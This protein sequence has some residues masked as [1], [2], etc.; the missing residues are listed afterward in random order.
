MTR[1]L[2]RKRRRNPFQIAGTALLVILIAIALVL[3]VDTFDLLGQVR[4]EMSL[5]P[6]PLPVMA[7]VM[8]VTPD[9]N[10]PTAEPLIKNGAEGEEVAK[11][12]QRLFDL[13]FYEGT[14]DGQFGQGTQNA[15]T[16]F[17][18]QHGL[19]ADGIVGPQTK[20]WLYSGAANKAVLTPTPA[21]TEPP[22]VTPRATQNPN[23]P[24][25][26]NKSTPI[27]ESYQAPDLVKM[28]DVCDS[29]LVTIKYEDTYANREATEA[30][31][32]MLSA[33]HRDGITVWQVSAGYRTY[34][35]QKTLFD[36]Q[37]NDYLRSNNLSREDAISATRQTVADPGTSEHHTGLAFDLTVPGVPFKGTPQSQW[38][39]AS[40]WDY[41]F[42]IRYT[43]DKKNI[44]GFLA[45]PWHVRYVG[46]EH[47]LF[48]RDNGLC[49][50]EYIQL[51]Q[52]GSL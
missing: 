25:L 33:A 29:A 10:K 35:M 22:V 4:Y 17:Q 52:G 51:K 41:G 7:N 38:L 48:M 40:C 34:E 18:S 15:V 8:Q 26:V 9:P 45:E 47:A 12:Q 1:S 2:R 14:V 27:E 20:E 36:A 21:P 28:T 3:M 6:T 49:L 19:T 50:E 30:L 5:T 42:I 39:A 44:T 16:A 13:G 43:E 31:K 37:V 11:I 23:L 46:R 32:A 24:F